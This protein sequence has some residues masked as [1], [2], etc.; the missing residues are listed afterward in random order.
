LTTGTLDN[1]RAISREQKQTAVLLHLPGNTLNGSQDE[2]QELAG[3]IQ[4]FA[5]FDRSLKDAPFR[6][7]YESGDFHSSAYDNIARNAA[8]I[9][10]TVALAPFTA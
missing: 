1:L 6:V 5:L 3:D 4:A 7:R 8:F 9:R 10:E 2:M